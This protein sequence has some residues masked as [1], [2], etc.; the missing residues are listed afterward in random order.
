MEDKSIEDQI[1]E[2]ATLQF[3]D[4]EIATVMQLPVMDMVNK[5]SKA[6]D[7]GRLL[8]EAE[9]RKSVYELAKQGSTPAQKQFMDLN[10][11]A[12]MSRMD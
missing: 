7:R 9:V 8:A 10:F 1:E 5:F 4:K 6:I 2:F 12:K 11:K 3:T